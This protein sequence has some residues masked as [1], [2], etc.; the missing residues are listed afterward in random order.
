MASREISSISARVTPAALLD[1]DNLPVPGVAGDW[2]G[3]AAVNASWMD[4]AEARINDPDLTRAGHFSRLPELEAIVNCT[5]AAAYGVNPGE[6]F[7][8]LGGDI[9]MRF[10]VPQIG[11]GSVYATHLSHPFF[12]LMNSSLVA[13]VPAGTDDTVAAGATT[14]TS[15]T[16]ATPAQ[17]SVGDLICFNVNNRLEFTGITQVNAAV[18]TVSPALENAPSVGDTLRHCVTFAPESGTGQDTIDLRFDWENRRYYAFQGRMS[19]ISFSFEGDTVFADVTWT[20]SVILKD[21]AN[22]SVSTWVA[23][24]APA[25]NRRQ[26]RWAL[27]EKIGTTTPGALASTEIPL[28]DWKFTAN[29]ALQPVASPD[30]VGA[31]EVAVGFS[32]AELE[33]QHTE[34]A[35]LEDMLRLGEERQAMIGAGPGCSGTG[36]GILLAGHPISKSKEGESDTKLEVVTTVLRSGKWELDDG[37]TDTSDKSYRIGFPM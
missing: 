12:Q 33:L 21:D 34:L 26:S 20:P 7:M 9:S 27:S 31:S 10:R 14:K 3:L 24:G 15:F 32:G 23:T 5:G 37:S 4:S 28:V 29:F 13:H 36:M 6:K 19:S 18:I 2:T 17:Y 8:Q 25:I 35:G 1:S 16:A 11:D 30:V 22:A